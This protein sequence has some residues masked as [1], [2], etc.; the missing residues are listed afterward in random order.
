ME[1][2]KKRI[3]L[4]TGASS[5]MGADFAQLLASG[6]DPATKAPFDELWLVA[7]R[8]DRL[9]ALAA[10][11]PEGVARILPLDLAGEVGLGELRALMEREAPDLRFLALNAGFGKFGTFADTPRE[12]LLGMVDL[13]VR[14][15][16]ALAKDAIPFMGRGSSLVLT[17]SL[18]GVMPIGGMAVYAASKAYVA[19]LGAALRAEL[20]ESGIR[21]LTLFP[22][23][24]ATE[25]FEV[26]GKDA[27]KEP[28]GAA[29]SVDVVAGCLR[30][31]GKGKGWSSPRPLWAFSTVAGRFLP[32]GLAARAG[33]AWARSVSRERRN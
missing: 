13:N 24:V 7:R 25:F 30:D 12:E 29:R 15:L 17:S 22:G 20:S 32:R 3:A 1:N 18:A 26:A 16:T 19:S 5:G 23:P 4:I 27:A 2:H 33:F 10:E 11:L 28:R 31:L 6:G 9:E 14:S 8:A 21:V